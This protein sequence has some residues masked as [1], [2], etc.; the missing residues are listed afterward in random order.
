MK[1]KCYD[2]SNQLKNYE[3]EQ[4]ILSPPRRV[5]RYGSVIVF[6]L[7][8]I[9]IICSLIIQYP[10]I[11]YC[12]GKL[13]TETK[14]VKIASRINGNIEKL[15][16]PDRARVSK[17]TTLVKLF[18]PVDEK[19]L[20][21]TFK[22]LLELQELFD[23]NID[24]NTLHIVE[25]LKTNK[26]LFCEFQ[27]DFNK[28][29]ETI[30]CY[31]TLINGQNFSLKSNSIEYQIKSLSLINNQLTHKMKL[32]DDI[33]KVEIEEYE[34]YNLLFKNGSISKFDFYTQG[35]KKLSAE[36]DLINAKKE[37]IDN[38]I[39]L[40]ELE[41]KL[42][43]L[44]TN[45]Y[46]QKSVLKGELNQRVQKFRAS[47]TQWKSDYIIN[48]PIDGSVTYNKRL[49]KNQFVKIGEEICTLIPHQNLYVIEATVSASDIGRIKL[50]QIAAFKLIAFPYKKFGTIKAEVS[51]IFLIPGD[52]NYL[53][54]LNIL[55]ESSNFKE[56]Y[57][58]Y[59]EMYG[60]LEI[61]TEKK[62]FL[63]HLFDL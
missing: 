13:S 45:Y 25:N 47:L 10:K 18:S 22:I 44:T 20:S 27:D 5:L 63:K 55:P 16:F 4:L 53:I 3:L 11:V 21:E 24:K 29:L 34:T 42:K 7:F 1:E 8:M 39:K 31:I 30:D 58:L 41:T 48:S 43:L 60:T 37:C 28:I 52:N 50:K 54:L 40:K 36:K 59:P 6:V 14:I 61:I 57:N 33:L 49:S 51:K 17:D 46:E 15:Y 38:E 35:I 62:T 32:L 56:F 9:C 19:Q 12:N 26:P 23:R 2:F